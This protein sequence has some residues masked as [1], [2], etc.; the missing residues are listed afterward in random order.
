[1]FRVSAVNSVGE[2]QPSLSSSRVV[3]PQE[4]P[5]GPPLG[6]VGSARS[7]SQIMIQWRPP[8]EEAQ[9]GDILGY[10]V[11]YRLFGY[12]DS[13]WS[14][15]NVTKPLQRTYLVTELITWK[16]YEVQ[17]A[18]Y[19]SKGVGSYSAAIKVKTRE[20]VPSA[21]PK[22]VRAQAIDSSVAR[23]W[24]YPPD[25][26]KINGINQGYKLQ[27]WR[28]IEGEEEQ[29]EDGEE[30]E[31]DATVSVAP[32]LLN[33]LS[34]QTSIIDGLRP[35]TAY[36]IT[37]L[38]FTS[39]GDGVRS[40]AEHIRTHQDYPGAVSSLRFEDITDRGVRVLWDKPEEPNGILTGYTV[41]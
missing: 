19:N 10:V 37:V 24:W 38:C 31:P 23:V 12:H 29:L 27:A 14:Y 9:N 11:R 35:W 18:A 26:Q 2:G 40:P 3:L 1:M 7:V 34:E 6:L 41:R 15:R 33:P 16:D 20:G 32:D 8:S 4:P 22:G 39:P 30:R 5:S 36:N 25:P 17:I 21:P 28:H 13:P